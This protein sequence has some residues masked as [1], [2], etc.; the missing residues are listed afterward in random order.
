MQARP[1][2]QG[3]TGQLWQCDV[4]REDGKLVAQGRVRLQNVPTAGVLPVPLTIVR[5][6]CPDP[7]SSRPGARLDGQTAAVLRRTATTR[8]FIV[9]LSEAETA[10]LRSF[11][12]AV[13]APKPWPVGPNATFRRKNE[14]TFVVKDWTTMGAGKALPTTVASAKLSRDGEVD[15][16]IKSRG[17]WLGYLLIAVGLV[18]VALVPR[19]GIPALFFG[20][21]FLA[22]GWF[23][24]LSTAW[25]QADLD[26]VES[27]MRR[28]LG[29]D[30]H[31]KPR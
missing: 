24:S 21:V 12:N 18:S 11:D 1:I 31:P 14:T 23:W 8:R 27:A 19:D 30:W 9:T 28:E 6:T 13:D 4:T 25:R 10:G 7:R 17:R 22:F 2:H 29:G 26:D 15:V 16:V 3:R 20:V 5:R